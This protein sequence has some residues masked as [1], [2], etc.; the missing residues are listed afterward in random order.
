[1]SKGC[2]IHYIFKYFLENIVLPKLMSVG[3]EAFL[4]NNIMHLFKEI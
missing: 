4:K 2:N 1:M 3:F